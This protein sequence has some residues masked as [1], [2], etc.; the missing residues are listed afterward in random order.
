MKIDVNGP[1]LNPLIPDRGARQ[2]SNGT[3]AVN[4]SVTED[5][6]TFH[7]DSASVQAL[8]SQAMQTPETRQTKVD[9]LSQSVSSGEYKANAGEIAEGI[10]ASEIM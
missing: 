6:T 5:R 9:A 2:V 8:T 7:S 4:E 10:L 1:V 3:I